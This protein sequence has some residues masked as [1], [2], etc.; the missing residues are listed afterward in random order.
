MFYFVQ[1]NVQSILNDEGRYSKKIL[2]NSFNMTKIEVSGVFKNFFPIYAPKALKN[3][4]ILVRQ[5]M[6]QLIHR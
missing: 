4:V 5:E 2:K 1:Y 3:V 6:K